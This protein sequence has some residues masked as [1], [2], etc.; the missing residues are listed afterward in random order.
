MT[1]NTQ[2]IN[3]EEFYDTT[4]KKVGSII[5]CGVDKSTCLRDR[6]SVSHAYW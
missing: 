4:I 3:W 1:K 6:E 2:V 5:H